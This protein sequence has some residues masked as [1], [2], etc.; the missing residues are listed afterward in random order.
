VLTSTLAGL[1]DET[2]RDLLRRQLE[3]S[4]GQPIDGRAALAAD[5]LARD[6]VRTFLFEEIAAHNPPLTSEFLRAL[7]TLRYALPSGGLPCPLSFVAGD[8]DRL[9][10]LELIRT[11]HAG[12]PGARLVVVPEAGHSVYFER[13]QA[14]NDVLAELLA[15][16]AGRESA[17]H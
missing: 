6:P 11:V 8:R 16:P 10:P 14:F 2:V 1:H 13:P 5:F 17:G 7:V 15:A 12:V 9:F 3:Q 4:E